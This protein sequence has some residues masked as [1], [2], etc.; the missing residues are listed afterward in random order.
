MMIFLSTATGYMAITGL[1][2]KFAAA[3]DIAG[4]PI[5]WQAAAI[6]QL[7]SRSLSGGLSDRFGRGAVIVP[8]LLLM[9][10]GLIT[11]S[12][13]N[14]VPMLLLAGLVIGLA[15]AGVQTTISALVVDRSSEKDLSSSLA[16]YTLAWDF[17]AILGQ[18]GF[19]LLVISL[20]MSNVFLLLTL[21]PLGAVL[22]YFRKLR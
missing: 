16:T 3:R 1:L 11:L 4:Y 22:L 17:G 9:S 21:L 7:F 6:G 14:T 10:V 19:G 5:F 20:G 12:I 18:T 15:N 13:A 8:M 2:P